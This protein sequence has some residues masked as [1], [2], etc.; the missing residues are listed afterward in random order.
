[1]PTVTT[2]IEEQYAALR[3]RAGLVEREG[4]GHIDVT[5]PDAP[6]FL[7]GQ[8]TNDVL[9]LEPG[10]G[11]YAA[12]LTPKGRIV[13]DMRILVRAPGEIW[14]DVPAGARD[15]VTRDLRVYKI[16]RQ[17]E[18]ADRTGESGQLSVI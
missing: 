1:M 14:V 12:M 18:I 8:V 4:R 13:A 10:T 16:G 11:C 6:D 5:G 17:V 15:A 9:A 7:Q 3:E 2:G